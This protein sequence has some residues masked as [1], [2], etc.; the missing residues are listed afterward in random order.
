MEIVLISDI[1]LMFDTP[2]GRTD[3]VSETQKKKM[4]FIVE[5]AHSR[6]AI[7]LQA[8]DFFHAARSWHL[9][10]EWIRFFNDYDV[11][12]YSVFGQHDT[13]MHSAET[14][15]FT[16]LGI[17]NAAGVVDILG[18]KPAKYISSGKTIEIYGSSWGEDIPKV[19][20][21]DKID[22]SI[23]AIHKQIVPH[24]L[25]SEQRE[26]EYAP[27]FLNKH[28]DFDLILAGDCHRRFLFADKG[29]VICSTGCITRYQADKYNF[30]EYEP[31]FYVYDTDDSMLE[32]IEIPH[33]P[34]SKVLSRKHIDQKKRVDAMLDEFIDAIEDTT[35]GLTESE[36]VDFKTNL[37][38]YCKRYKIKNKVLKVLA[39]TID[40]EMKW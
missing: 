19:I 21:K 24:K 27:S 32:W 3:N 34:A 10:E 16:N 39:Q 26:F 23:L 20:A 35:E 17:L 18:E 4:K 25:W 28:R 30:E 13:Y 9:A 40:E 15:R 31:G 22:I 36:A 33:Q 12:I 38:E 8:G 14:R 11:K 37:V 6:D 2:I 5:Y 7:I 29:R 1:H